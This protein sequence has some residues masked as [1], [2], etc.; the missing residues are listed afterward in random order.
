M[1]ADHRLDDRAGSKAPHPG[2]GA[3]KTS[4]APSSPTNSGELGWAE[5]AVEYFSRYYRL[6]QPEAYVRA[7]RTPYI[8]KDPSHQRGGRK[9]GSATLQPQFAADQARCPWLSR[10]CRGNLRP[11]GTRRS[12]STALVR[13]NVGGRHDREYQLARRFVGNQYARHR[14]GAFS[15]GNFRV[16][17]RPPSKDIP[18]LRGSWPSGS[19]CSADEIEALYTCIRSTGGGHHRGPGRPTS[20]P[21][22]HLR[23]GET[24]AGF[25][26]AP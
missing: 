10:P 25:E 26:S 8:E 9:S 5:Q 2:D 19:R 20:S 21:P 15:R 6:L 22:T 18:G 7:A 14:R 1:S 11:F 23:G 12:T 13:L 17:R 3:N 4:A 24:R 16:P